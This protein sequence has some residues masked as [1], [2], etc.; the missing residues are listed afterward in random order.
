MPVSRMR[1]RPWLEM[2]IDSN[3]IPGLVWINRDKKIFQIPWKHAARHGWTMD[4]DA[5]LFRQWAIHTGKYK[6][7]NSSPDPK[8]WKANFR[9][10]MNSLPDIEEVKDK[11]INKGSSAIRVYRMLPPV[12][13]TQRKDKKSRQK[14]NKTKQNIKENDIKT[15]DESS[16]ITDVYLP[17]DHSGYTAHQGTSLQDSET[18]S[19]QCSLVDLNNI[20]EHTEWTNTVEVSVADSTNDMFSFQVSPLHSPDDDDDGNFDEVIQIAQALEQDHTQWRPSSINGRGFLSN[21]IGMSIEPNDIDVI[22]N[23]LQGDFE[24]RFYSELRTGSDPSWPLHTHSLASL[25]CL[26]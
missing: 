19:S 5:C 24:F 21:S 1:M 11:S 25:L 26:H 23:D 17:D 18:D 13:K 6:P 8:T 9:C 4:K 3:E 16:D 22:G 12:K 15:E 14:D 10:A 2:K 7:G 20:T